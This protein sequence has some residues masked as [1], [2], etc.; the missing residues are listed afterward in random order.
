MQINTTIMSEHIYPGTV[1]LH[2][3]T[4]VIMQIKNYMIK[5]WKVL[6][7]EEKNE[8]VIESRLKQ[9]NSNDKYFLYLTKTELE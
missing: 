6:M 2:C 9:L 3:F 5:Y 8:L 7:N 1:P 4:L